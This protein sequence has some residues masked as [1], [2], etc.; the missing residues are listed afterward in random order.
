MVKITKEAKN[1]FK[2][3]FGGHIGTPRSGSAKLGPP[4]LDPHRLFSSRIGWALFGA[5]RRR[6]SRF[7]SLELLHRAMVEVRVLS[8]ALLCHADGPLGSGEI[9]WEIEVGNFARNK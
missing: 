4:L 6:P 5:A 9:S 8:E 7:I 1:G 2:V 3:W